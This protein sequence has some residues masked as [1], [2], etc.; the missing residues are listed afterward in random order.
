MSNELALERYGQLR[1]VAGDCRGASAAEKRCRVAEA[2]RDLLGISILPEE[3]PRKFREESDSRNEIDRY[4]LAYLSNLLPE[5]TT[6]N[7]GRNVD[8]DFV[9]FS[10]EITEI[11]SEIPSL[12]R[13][14]VPVFLIGD[15]GTGKGQVVRAMGAE[16]GEEPLAVSLAA[17]P[18]DLADVELFGHRKGAF[19][20]AEAQRTGI[21][22]TAHRERRLLFLDD[23]SECSPAVQAKLL[24]VLDDGV[25]RQ[26]GSDDVER[27]GRMA[28]RGFGL[29]S[30][31][32]PGRVGELRR[33][34]LDRLSAIPVWI[35]PLANRGLDILLLADYFAESTSGDGSTNGLLSQGARRLLLECSWPGNVRQLSNV[36]WR[37]AHE[38]G[39]RAYIDEGRV[40]RALAHEQQ[41]T[42]LYGNGGQSR[43]SATEPLDRSSTDQGRLP[44]MAEMRDRHFKRALKLAGGNVLK[45]ASL[46]DLDASTVHRWRKKQRQSQIATQ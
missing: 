23:V 44:T 16:I 24:A 36:I 30:A 39:K 32:Q 28:D 4:S 6:G 42:E 45:A 13:T 17:M 8:T 5:T 35:P 34:L 22:L 14:R 43:S 19:T 40:S 37:A 26:V 3:L 2:V 18:E 33:D 31:S 10:R 20:G 41:L 27:I 11:R 12:A 15:R 21:L 9:G 46:L 25:V 1:C 38:S 29:V 7:A